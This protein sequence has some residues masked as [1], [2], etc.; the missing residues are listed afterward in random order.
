MSAERITTEYTTSTSPNSED[1]TT[2]IMSPPSLEPQNTSNTSNSG[3]QVSLSPPIDESIRASTSVSSSQ[4]PEGSESE[5]SQCELQSKIREETQTASEFL[6]ENTFYYNS[7][8]SYIFPGAELWWKDSDNESVSSDSS[9]DDDDD[10]DD[11]IDNIRNEL[12][13]SYTAQENSQ[14]SSTYD[15]FFT[16]EPAQKDTDSSSCSSSNQYD[17]TTDS[18]IIQTIDYTFTSSNVTTTAEAL[19]P[20]TSATMHLSSDA[21]GT[22]SL[23]KR[24]ASPTVDDVTSIGSF[25]ATDAHKRIKLSEML[26]LSNNSINGGKISEN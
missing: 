16:S 15:M 13:Q 1:A 6:P 21:A 7:K 10:V 18:G 23:R 8:N 9:S 17:S 5:S 2:D 4:T 12:E 26:L 3:A 14:L 20:A 19:T 24:N 22:Q 11:E 25:D